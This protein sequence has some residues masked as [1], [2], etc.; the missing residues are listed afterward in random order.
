[1]S[2][3]FKAPYT[4]PGGMDVITKNLL[5][6]AEVWLDEF[7]ELFYVRMPTAKSIDYGNIT[8]RS[9]NLNLMF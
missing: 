9:K 2:N 8:G 3:I 5:R 6:V 7:K 4:H 1:M